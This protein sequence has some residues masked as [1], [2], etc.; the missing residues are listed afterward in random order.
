[1]PD[2]ARRGSRTKASST[3]AAAAVSATI[4][5]E[6]EAPRR[7]L[8]PDIEEINSSLRSSADR[9]DAIDPT[10]EDIVATKKRGFRF[11]FWFVL[12][13]ILVLWL[14][15]FFSDHLKTLAPS[16]AGTLDSYVSTVDNGRIWLDRTV[17]G[18]TE[19]IAAEP[20]AATETDA[21]DSN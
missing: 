14:I 20:D 16:M 4:A 6:A 7:D 3:A 5:H 9:G 8:L 17:Q 12:V 21:S 19:K 15:Y 10:P 18:V 1:M 11:G 2:P 13:L